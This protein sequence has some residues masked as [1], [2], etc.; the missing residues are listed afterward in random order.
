MARDFVGA[1]LRD[2]KRAEREAIR[3]QKAAEREHRALVRQAESITET[4]ILISIATN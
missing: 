3:A 2:I 1:W 4:P